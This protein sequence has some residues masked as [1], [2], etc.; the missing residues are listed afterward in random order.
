MNVYDTSKPACVPH[1]KTDSVGELSGVGRKHILKIMRQRIGAIELQLC[2]T[3][4][5]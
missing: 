3:L 5:W 2:M 1:L 4:K